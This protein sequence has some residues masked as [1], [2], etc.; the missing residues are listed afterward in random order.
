M[1]LPEAKPHRWS[2]FPGGYCLDC[3]AES[4]MENAMGQ[5]WVQPP[6]PVFPGGEPSPEKWKSEKHKLMVELC[7]KYCRSQMTDEDF[8]IVEKELER[9]IT[10]ILEDAQKKQ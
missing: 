7:D 9:I 6:F 5:G 2:G 4:A 3:G 1:N 8:S 10:E